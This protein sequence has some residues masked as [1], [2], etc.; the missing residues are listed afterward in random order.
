MTLRHAAAWLLAGTC[1][2]AGPA[3]A[4]DPAD[5]RT[6]AGASADPA[7]TD[8]GSSV[9]TV[10]G[11]NGDVIV[12]APHYVPQGSASASK[13]DIPLIATPQSVS[14]VTRDQIDL[15]DFVDAQQAVRYT[16]GVFG[17]NY[18]PDSRYDFF[19]VRGFTPRQFIDGLATPVSTTIQSVGVDLYGFESLELLKGPSATLYGNVPPGGIFNETS[20]RASAT[21]GG[22]IRG[23]YGTDNFAEIAGTV[24]GPVADGIAA[25]GT[26]LFRDRDLVPD[27][28]GNQRIYFAPT[29]TWQ[30]TPGTA[31]T[32]LGY[33]QYDDNK[34]GQGGFLPVNG[35]LLPNPNGRISQRTNLDDPRDVF[36]R[37]QFA[38]GY[39]FTSRLAEGVDFRSAARWNQYRERTPIGI[40][41][42]A[43]AADNRTI[44]QS[45][46][47]Y[48]EDVGSFTS[49]NRLNVHA[50]TGP[51]RHNL[52]VGVDY[53][54]Q[55]NNAAYG[56]F[57]A[58]TLDLYD[59]VYAT[60]DSA[61]VESYPTRYSD[62]RLRQTGVYGQEQAQI[63]D[64][65]LTVGGRYDW[66]RLRY[67]NA[68]TAAG[69][70][71]PVNRQNEHAFTWRAGANYV[72]AGGIAPYLSYSRS[73]EPVVGTD[74]VTLQ[75]FRP[76][77][78]RQ[79]EGG[80]KFDGR[81]LGPDVRL[82]ATAAVFDIRQN[83]VVATLSNI[84]PVFGTQ[85][86]ALEVYGGEL[87]LVARIR[88]QLTI[89]GSYS[90]NH[91]EVTR[92]NVAAEV[93]EPLPTTPR[94][95]ASL[96]VNYQVQR[97]ALAGF[98]LG[99]GVRYTSSSAGSLPGAF[100]PVVY[101]GESATLVDA[102]VSYELPHW[103]F[104]VNG[105]NILDHRY[106]ARCS[107]PVGC[108]YGAP[109]QVLGTVTRR[110]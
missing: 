81:Q 23:Q 66:V 16:A 74:A 49:D 83:N 57:A 47:T 89:N 7:I 80:V 110:F 32:L 50:S 38:G 98:G 70:P 31:L 55:H 13:T 28:T 92:S 1:L 107:G 60:P 3:F 48:A 6:D 33:Y 2:V 35:T 20:R 8:N 5:Q 18:G 26:F 99:G 9:R 71:S 41:P 91:S 39:E 100:N 37:R 42:T 65:Y 103:R 10:T 34:G 109:R 64:L 51:V 24:T 61:L 78:G 76:S 62:Q 44:S 73:F 102:I 56:F 4:Q 94:H 101:R 11:D 86:G 53:R 27:H 54:T 25:R 90:Y 59:P 106:V 97:G 40:Y 52:L 96:F 45:N 21:F 67:L 93:G 12:T 30:I 82:F 95:K 108:F 22:E 17:E 68:F 15:L 69:S 105:S 46:F 63:G 75:P 58:G 79:W 77:R 19:T 36:T 43:L 104:A 85:S 84:G 88:D 29:A 87:E 72:T 14:V